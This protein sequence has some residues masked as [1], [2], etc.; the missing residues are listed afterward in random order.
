MQGN[1]IYVDYERRLWYFLAS[2]RLASI[3][4]RV[5]IAVS[6]IKK[7]PPFQAAARHI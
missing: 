5:R 7:L 4:R 3:V 1:I 2:S 6:D